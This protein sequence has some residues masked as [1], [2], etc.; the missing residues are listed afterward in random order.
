LLGALLIVGAEF[1]FASMGASIR[2]LSASLDNHTVVFAR[3][4]IG[5]VLLL[6]IIGAQPGL[7][8]ATRVPAL[9]LMR[10]LAGVGAMYCFFYAIAHLPL[11]DAM[12]LK[13]SAPLFIPFVALLWLREP[14]GRTVVVAILLGFLGVGVILTPD[15]GS[16]GPVAAIALLGG[17]LAAVAK[18]T[19]RRL[20][21]SEPPDR[22]VFYFALIGTGVSA[23]PVTL[24]P[25]LPAPSDLPWLVAVAGFATFGQMLLTRGF[26]ASPAARLGPF[27]FFSVV[28]AAA[29]GWYFWQEP[30]TLST[31]FGSLL[32]L[33][34]ALL[35]SRPEATARRD[36][37][38]FPDRVR[39]AA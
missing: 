19:V 28:F 34:A 8:L 16:L 12:L 27:A 22:I 38:L 23:V 29:F 10:G 4:L 31:V 14:F 35:V 1:M 39:K 30:L 6:P 21:R 13:L 2:H 37:N 9:H 26:A 32:V 24:S 36:T 33:V 5:L 7:R 3:N 25:Q 20:S 18:V 17:A 11:A 15:F